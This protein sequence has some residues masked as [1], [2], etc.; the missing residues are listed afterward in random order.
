MLIFLAVLRLEFGVL[1]LVGRHS[2]TWSIPP[3]L[4]AVVILEIEYYFL[5]R[6]VWISILLFYIS[7][8]TWDDKHVPPPQ[9]LVE[10]GDSH[11]LFAQAGLMQQSS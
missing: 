5:P 3:A 7:C 11:E 1:H 2:T 4:C 6:P 10:G 9:L 8:H